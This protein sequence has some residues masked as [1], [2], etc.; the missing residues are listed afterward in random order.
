MTEEI[1]ANRVDH[2]GRNLRAAGSVKVGDRLAAMDS[3]QRREAITDLR[4]RREGISACD[5]VVQAI[6]GLRGERPVAGEWIIATKIENFVERPK[7]TSPATNVTGEALCL[8]AALPYWVG[9][10]FG[11]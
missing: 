5:E 9:P 1:V 3:P 8:K 2:G 6:L 7:E 11:R 4:Q 10:G